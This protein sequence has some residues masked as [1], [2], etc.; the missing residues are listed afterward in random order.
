MEVLKEWGDAHIIGKIGVLC[1]QRIPS[2]ANH[3]NTVNEKPAEAGFSIYRLEFLDIF[4]LEPFWSLD[5][6]K[7]DLVPFTQRFETA[8]GYSGEMN[9]NI[10]A[11]IVLFEKT[12][13]LAL[14]EPLYS[15]CRHLLC[16]LLCLE[17]L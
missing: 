14:V 9:K 8:A 7:P 12:E 17:I 15:T 13:S 5:N 1:K 6:L 3:L 2:K 11:S 10:T 4:R 16:L